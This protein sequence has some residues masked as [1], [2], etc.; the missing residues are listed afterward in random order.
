MDIYNYIYIFRVLIL[1]WIYIYILF[2]LIRVCVLSR[3]L[4]GITEFIAAGEVPAI[5]W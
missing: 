4:Q 5:T 2:Y 3:E 1:L